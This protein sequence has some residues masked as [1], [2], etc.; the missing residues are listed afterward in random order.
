[1]AQ[2]RDAGRY[3]VIGDRPDFGAFKTPTLRPRE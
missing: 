3:L 2:R 1:M